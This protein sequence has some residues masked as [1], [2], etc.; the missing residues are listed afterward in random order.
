MR[1][2]GELIEREGRGEAAR[3]RA[4]ADGSDRQAT[5]EQKQN[6]TEQNRTTARVGGRR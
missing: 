6:R 3:L 4:T 5:A 2:V 1:R